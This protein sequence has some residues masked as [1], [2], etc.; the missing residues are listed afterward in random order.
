M[1]IFIKNLVLI[2]LITNYFSCEKTLPVFTMD[3][4]PL[5][6]YPNKISPSVEVL[7]VK[8]IKSIQFDESNSTLVEMGLGFQSFWL[9]HTQLEVGLKNKSEK[10]SN[11]ISLEVKNF[12]NQNEEYYQLEIGENQITILGQSLAG[13]YRG[14]KTLEQIVSLSHLSGI[15]IIKALPTGTIE[16]AP[17]YG[18]RGAMLD[19][20]RHFFSVEDV[21]RYIDLLSIYKINFLHLHLSDDQGWR[22]EIKAWPKLTSIGGKTEVGGSEGGFY[23]QLDY[24]EII[25]YAQ[26]HFITIVPEID[27]PGHT[28]A[29][30]ASYAELNCDNEIKELYTGT[31][32]GFSTLCVDNE[33][34]Y[35]FVS[36]VV[37]EISTITPGDYFHI[38]G[39]ESHVTP[40]K[41]YIKFM[42]RV[43]DIVLRNNKTP[44][45][46]DEI[47]LADIPEVTVAQYWAK[48]ENAIMAMDKKANVLM[49]PASYAYLDM[50]YD[51]ITRLGLKWAGYISVQKGYEWDP[52]LLVPELDSTRIIGIEA[53]IWT[54]TLEDFDDIAQM[55]FPR[56]LGYSEIGWTKSEKR[57]WEK[58]SS[59]L[60][61]HS[62]I[63][64]SLD[65]KFYQTSEINWE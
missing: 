64:D 15:Q 16:D 7:N 30:L 37:S 50:K 10:N 9:S 38:G 35:K 44:M 25:A 45:G 18:Y 46:W 42:N 13:V 65:I 5:I 11:M 2:I 3:K 57:D 55:A 22:I 40:K 53:P 51:S 48:A 20:S 12:S 43:I 31:E 41:D 49:S 34:T 56:I 63:L 33:L 8:K 26:R 23:S 47:V 6:P 28:N 36:D 1:K 17:V 21:K 14:V 60:S 58:Y 24:K 54:E 61:Y 19:V 52:A 4:I 59:R 62:A 32:V 39:D 27:M 29:V